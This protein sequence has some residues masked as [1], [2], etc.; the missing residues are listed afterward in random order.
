MAPEWLD[1]L[2]LGRSV[3]VWAPLQES[4]LLGANRESRTLW[5]LGR[6]REGRSARQ[7][8]SAINAAGDAAATVSVLPYT[9]LG[10]EAGS[11][12]DRLRTLLPAAAGAVFVIAC[13]NVAAFLLSRASARS[14]ETAVRVAI[15][16]SRGQLGRQLLADSILLSL[17]GGACGVLLAT[18]TSQIIPALFFDQDA[19]HLV[20]A[21]RVGA[22]VLASAVCAIITI[23]C[24]LLP[25]VEIRD[26][27]PAL[28]L[29]RESVGPSLTMQR[30]RAAL[31]VAQM[32]C[33]CLLIVST[34]LLLDGFRAALKTTTGARL[35]RPI[36]ATLKAGA[37]FGSPD[38]GLQYFRDAERA[39][40][41]L[42][43]IYE[44]AWV[45][46]PP[47]SRASWQSVRIEPQAAQVREAIMTVVP[48]TVQ[49]LKQIGTSPVK[50]RLFGGADK[51]RSCRVAVVNEEAASRFFNGNAVGRSIEDLAGQ[52]VEIVGVAGTGT[53]RTPAQ[54]AGP[55]IYFYPQQTGMTADQGGPATFRVP[56]YAEPEVTGVVDANIVSRSYFA[57]MD[58]APVA[59]RI[60]DEAEPG[61][62]RV[63]VVNEEASELYF[64]G[65]AVGGAVIDDGGIR[66]NIVGVVHS[67][68]L[69]ATERAVE[70]T[71]YLP[72]EQDYQPRM[73]LVLGTQQDDSAIVTA[74]RQQLATVGGGETAG[75]MTLEAHLGRTALA[76][77]RIAAMLVAASAATALTLGVLGIYGSLTDFTRRRRPEI[78]LRIALG[79]QR[80]RVMLQVLREGA[81][82]AGIGLIAGSLASVPVARWLAR[83]TPEAG[84]SSA[85]VWL[86]APLVLVLAVAIASVLPMR[87]AL[88]VSPLSVM[89]DS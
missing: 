20:L 62:C 76:S 47:G 43:G 8:E 2:Y 65:R 77:E 28:V 31:V 35:G 50:G 40:L 79:A 9:G 74:V 61:A 85:W 51:P 33:C 10:P 23:A 72:L 84:S 24:G 46:T 63:G 66:T 49:T 27:D 52:R 59:G 87:R 5:V 69:R 58:V 56:L 36:L 29:R 55:A 1:G 71:I 7:A 3:D 64:G 42:P 54:P 11:G 89:R 57:A 18:W 83:L 78:A 37:G 15:G 17:A 75:V 81:R 34:V 82:L 48:F 70:P 22:V 25:L 67:A 30:V 19:E 88:A 12:M 53:E 38:L 14:Q 80:W 26:D 39:A 4:S 68:P 6:L 21:P 44:T 16:A 60:F 32:A 86:A 13:A 73:T 45:G 41:A